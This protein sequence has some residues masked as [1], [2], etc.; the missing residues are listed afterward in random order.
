M[1]SFAMCNLNIMLRCLMVKNSVRK[2]KVTGLNPKLARYNFFFF[3]LTV[4]S[5]AFEHDDLSLFLSL[6]SKRNIVP[7][8][9]WPIRGVSQRLFFIQV[10]FQGTK[11]YEI[12]V[13]QH[14]RVIVTRLCGLI[15][16]KSHTNGIDFVCTQKIRNIVQ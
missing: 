12:V 2:H 1:S 8:N 5:P 16:K 13:K 9:R 7:L 14:V 11:P 6:Y 4:P 3:F 15:E 10:F